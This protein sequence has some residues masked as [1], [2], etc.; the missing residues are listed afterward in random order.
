MLQYVRSLIDRDVA[1]EGKY[2]TLGA[3]LTRSG[4][5][6]A[7]SRAAGHIPWTVARRTFRYQNMKSQSAPQ[8]M[9][10]V[11]ATPEYTPL[12][13]IRSTNGMPR[14]RRAVGSGAAPRHQSPVATWYARLTENNAHRCARSRCQF[15]NITSSCA[16]S[17]R[18]VEG[19]ACR[20]PRSM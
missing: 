8:Q 19:V 4:V 20:L 6:S 17:C 14:P 7:V 13:C 9:H 11:D 1:D 2:G 12:Q 16:S 15:S 5:D 3:P 18:S 10:L